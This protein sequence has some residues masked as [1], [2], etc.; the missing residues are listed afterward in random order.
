MENTYENVV[1]VK[2]VRTTTTTVMSNAKSS[3]AE[4]MLEDEGEEDGA[5]VSDSVAV[6]SVSFP[7]PLRPLPRSND[8]NSP[9]Y[10]QGLPINYPSSSGFSS[11]GQM[12]PFYENYIIKPKPV[13]ACNNQSTS[14]DYTG[15]SVNLVELLI[16]LIQ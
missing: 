8:D 3:A 7:A 2:A 13:Y 11:T 4:A 16:R 12:D 9:A 14:V 6:A 5:D 10:K 1:S 15:K